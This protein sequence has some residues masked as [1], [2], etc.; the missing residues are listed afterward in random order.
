MDSEE[1]FQTVV[2][3]V[4]I[5]EHWTELYLMLLMQETN[6]HEFGEQNEKNYV[7]RWKVIKPKEQKM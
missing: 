6:F 4:K 3:K 2:C 7:I 1:I 5:V